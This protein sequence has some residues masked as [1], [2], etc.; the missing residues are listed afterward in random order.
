[1]FDYRLGKVKHDFEKDMQLRATELEELKILKQELEDRKTE[2]KQLED[3]LDEW[4]GKYY[5]ML[6]HLISLKGQ[7]DK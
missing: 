5:E 7:L 1:M 6:E 2:I 4:K 3:Q